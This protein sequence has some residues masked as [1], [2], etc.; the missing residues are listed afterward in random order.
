MITLPPIDLIF[1]GEA[2]LINYSFLKDLLENCK[3]FN[4][5]FPENVTS[6]DYKDVINIFSTE[7]YVDLII[8]TDKLKILKCEVPNV[9]INLGLNEGVLELLFFFD[10]ADLNI[11]GYKNTLEFLK[12]WAIE[13][14]DKHGFENILCQTDN[15]DSEEYYF[16]DDEFG[17]L[18]KR[19]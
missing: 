15:G 3:E 14:R 5:H 12:S 8:N 18:Y 6:T 16:D 13:F 7:E 2:S 19:L 10:L 1:K 9:F 4:F 11:G 17:P